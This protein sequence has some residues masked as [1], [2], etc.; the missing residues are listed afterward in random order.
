MLNNNADFVQLQEFDFGYN[1]VTEQQAL[2]FAAQ[3]PHLNLLVITGN[4]LGLAG[5][6]AYEQLEAQ[7][8]AAVSATLINEVVQGDS[9]FLKKPSKNR[10][11]SQFPYPNPIK[12]LSR[13]HQKEIKGEYLNAEMMHQGIALPISDIRPDNNIESEIFPPELTKE[14]QNKEVFTPPNHQQMRF[15]SGDEGDQIHVN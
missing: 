2:W 12:L 1:L 10:M 6:S 15:V 14:A 8:S 13:E 4:P 7:L 9:A 11:L 3:I 5:R